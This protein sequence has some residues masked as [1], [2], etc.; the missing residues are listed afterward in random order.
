[1]V[2]AKRKTYHV[3]NRPLGGRFFIYL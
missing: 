1:M 3:K 2:F